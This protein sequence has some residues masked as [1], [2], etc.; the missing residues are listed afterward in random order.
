MLFTGDSTGNIRQ[1]CLRTK[2]KITTYKN[3]TKKP[4]TALLSTHD[5]KHLYVGTSDG[6]LKL[7]QIY[8]Q[9]LLKD[10]G[11]ILNGSICSILI[12][13]DS[14][15]M[16]I[17]DNESHIL[18]FDQERFTDDKCHGIDSQQFVLLPMAINFFNYNRNMNLLSSVILKM[19]SE[20]NYM[21][22]KKFLVK[23]K[24]DIMT[25]FT[26]TIYFHTLDIL[27]MIY[28]FQWTGTDMNIPDLLKAVKNNTTVKR[29]NLNN[30]AYFITISLFGNENY[31]GNKVIE[32]MYEYQFVE[33][34]NFKKGSIE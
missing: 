29:K 33:V 32:H 2:G 25:N 12:S 20:N 18:Q 3:I 8:N 7:I 14:K 21:D 13:D 24:N 15:W 1:F 10:Y 22:L 30:F 31:I 17:C 19:I 5:T 26:S 23:Y 6:S 9:V 16:F 34:T 27:V 11:Q 28:A 4:I